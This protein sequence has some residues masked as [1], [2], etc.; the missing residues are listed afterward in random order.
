MPDDLDP[1]RPDEA[2]LLERVTQ[3]ESALRSR[4]V[5]EQ[6][7]G[8]LMLVHRCDED[9]A[10]RVLIAVSQAS[11]R[12]LRDIASELVRALPGDRALPPDLAEAFDAELR[13]AGGR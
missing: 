12:K 10:F 7:K 8:M 5:I 9:Q 1:S 11:N 13:R 6:A 3:L 4:P 2:S